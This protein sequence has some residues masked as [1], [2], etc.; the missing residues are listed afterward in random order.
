LIITETW[1]CSGGYR[2]GSQPAWPA[3]PEK[4]TSVNKP[5]SHIVEPP[6]H[7]TPIAGAVYQDV[8]AQLYSADLLTDVD[9]YVVEMFADAYAQWV[10]AI[11]QRDDYRASYGH[12][13]AEDVR[14]V[15]ELAMDV[16]R[17]CK[18]LG[19]GPMHRQKLNVAFGFGGEKT[20]DAVDDPVVL[21]ICNG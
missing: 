9:L 14:L 4:R 2:T 21:G 11:E 15:R 18:V 19:F 7:L 3:T 13:K 10:D 6:S 8:C 5:E 1:I 12:S 17:W 20:N 16:N